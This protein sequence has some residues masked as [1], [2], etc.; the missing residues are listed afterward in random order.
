MDV[1]VY[2][3]GFI[4]IGADINSADICR[5]YFSS[6]LSHLL[7]GARTQWTSLTAPFWTERR[8]SRSAGSVEDTAPV[9]G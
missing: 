5:K 9:T 1:Y 7:A 8:Q 3:Y 6:L 4:L 2:V